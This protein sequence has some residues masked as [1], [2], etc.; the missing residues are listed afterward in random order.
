VL[1]AGYGSDPVVEGTPPAE[2]GVGLQQTASRAGN[3]AQLA[4]HIKNPKRFSDV[5]V[6]VGRDSDGVATSP[7]GVTLEVTEET[8][9]SRSLASPAM[10]IGERANPPAV[11]T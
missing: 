8:Y 10:L 9:W 3:P 6:G 11:K 4:A 5:H 2:G 7:D 1:S